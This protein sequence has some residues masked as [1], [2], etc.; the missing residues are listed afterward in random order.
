MKWIV[1][2]L[3]NPGS[4]YEETRHNAGRDIVSGFVKKEGLG[5]WESV[6]KKKPIATVAKGKVGKHEALFVLPDLFMN[7]SGKVVAGY[8][9]SKAAAKN[10]LVVQDDLDLPLGT[11]KLAYGRGSGGHKGVESIMRAVKTKEFVRLRIGVSPHT[12][13]GKIKKPDGEKAVIDFVLGSWKPKEEES[14]KKIEKRAR[15]AIE[16]VMTE[17]LD[18]AM[19]VVNSQ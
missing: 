18:R 15:E 19:N 11:V 9:K 1:V 16:T 3:G 6:P 17:G 5:P 10:L 4:E 13:S 8:V 14:L 2:G 12:A 7:N